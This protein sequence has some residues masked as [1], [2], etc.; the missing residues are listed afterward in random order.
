MGDP[1]L[2]DLL[3]R[4]DQEGL[5]LTAGGDILELIQRVESGEED[6]LKLSPELQIDLLAFV[7]RY[8]TVPDWVDVAQLERGRTVFL[9]Y[10]PAMGAS[11]YYRSLVPG[12]SIPHLAAV[13]QSTGYLAP[14]ANSEHVTNRLLDTGAMIGACMSGGIDTLF[15]DGEGWKAVLY[16]RVLHAKVRRRLLLRKRTQW[17]TAKLGVPINQEDMAAT[18]LAFSIN[19]LYG[20]EFVAGM[21][22]SRQEQWDYL[23]L[24]RYIGWLLGVHT[25]TDED[26][27]I[28]NSFRPLDPCGPGWSDGDPIV[29]SRSLLESIISHLMKPNELSVIVANHLLTI[30]RAKDKNAENEKSRLAWY[31]FRCLQCRRYI[32]DPLADALQLPKYDIWWKRLLLFSAS[33]LYLSLLRIYTLVTIFIPPVRQSVQRYHTESLT[34]F[35]ENWKERHSTRMAKTLRETKEEL[36]SSEEEA[37]CPFAMV[38]PPKY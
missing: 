5:P 33:T 22:L 19:I 4:L 32:G 14:P 25:V 38:A 18:L 20:V 23:A 37:C 1:I 17:D 29:H 13:I 6:R 9:T 27:S 8:R 2:D 3:G 11:L 15:A 24:W 10:A 30:G 34:R 16:V 28:A 31:Y 35:Y 36:S 21:Q 12:F 26:V 7:A